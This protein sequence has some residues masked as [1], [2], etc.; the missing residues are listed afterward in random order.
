M[1]P[2]VQITAD[3]IYD[4]GGHEIAAHLAKVFGEQDAL[5]GRD[6]NPGVFLD[7]LW[8]RWGGH[9]LLSS[10]DDRGF[11]AGWGPG[12]DLNVIP[13]N[14]KPGVCSSV[15]ITMAV[16]GFGAGKVGR[17]SR[18][19]QD[20]MM[21]L[22]AYWFECIHINQENLILTPDWNQSKFEAKYLPVLDAYCRFHGKKVF[23]AE[24]S[25]S[26]LILRYPV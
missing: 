12:S 23:I 25:K 3:R 14:G 18:S 5:F 2:T 6:F 19:F 1:H 7:D 13:S 17:Y 15:C 9:E 24:V 10:S 21:L 4:L 16:S 22:A 8:R 20:V 26:G 11:G